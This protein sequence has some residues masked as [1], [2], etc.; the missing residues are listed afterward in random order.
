MPDPTLDTTSS[1]STGTWQDCF[2]TPAGSDLIQANCLAKYEQDA[3]YGMAKDTF[4]NP[5]KPSVNPEKVIQTVDG[6]DGS[7]Y[8]VIKVGEKFHGVKISVM[9]TTGAAI[10]LT[11]ASSIAM[12][13]FLY[14]S[15]EGKK[16][17]ERIF[18][19]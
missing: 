6:I 9:V 17:R 14:Y 10:V 8:L 7:K 19:K 13:G 16:F 11:G 15:K 3:S 12:V 5:W 1:S 18:G 2:A 4:F